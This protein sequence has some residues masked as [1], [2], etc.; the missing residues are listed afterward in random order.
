MLG[1]LPQQFVSSMLA[2][3]SASARDSEFG[4]SVLTSRTLHSEMLCDKAKEAMQPA[5]NAVAVCYTQG[6]LSPRPLSPT[7]TL[8]N[9]DPIPNS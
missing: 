2:N 9:P 5:L 3:S 8:I 4:I 6:L 7:Q 1:V